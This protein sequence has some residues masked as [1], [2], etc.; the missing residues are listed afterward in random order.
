M[1]TTNENG[2]I[3]K[4]GEQRPEANL[5]AMLE[6][7]GP[8]MA[9]ALPRH[10]TADRMARVVLTSLRTTKDLAKCTPA[11][12]MACVMTLAQL[13]LEPGNGL[14]FAYLIPRRNKGVMECTVILGYQGLMDL[15]RRSGQVS[16]ITAHAV[17][18]GDAF[19]CEYGLRPKLEHVPNWTA[20]RTP[21]RLIGAYAVARIKDS[22]EPTFVYVPRIEI[23]GFRKRGASGRT[24][25]KGEQIATPW[26]T[27][28]E[29]MAVKTAIRRL[30]KF[31]PKSVEM[32]IADR[33][34]DAPASVSVAVSEVAAQALDVSG[35]DVNELEAE[36]ETGEVVEAEQ[37]KAG[38]S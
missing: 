19:A 18:E 2:Q 24:N 23:E 28:Y 15:A 35:Y 7:M 31:L 25:W 30:W 5:V 13:G 8:Q 32:A 14:G 26:D 1:T 20:P 36:T 38:E 6:K 10:V 22:D 27:D 33:V 17:Y 4:R 29:A 37:A 16:S 11:S 12:F 3:Q 9:R 21:Q 34:D